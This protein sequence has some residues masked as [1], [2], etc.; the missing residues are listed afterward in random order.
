MLH[1]DLDNVQG[2]V[3]MVK[4]HSKPSILSY[5]VLIITTSTMQ[6]ELPNLIMKVHSHIP[7]QLHLA[8]TLPLG[9]N[10]PLDLC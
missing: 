6:I 10:Q 1:D 5:K 2:L 3:S 9:T 7:D 4:G 8:P